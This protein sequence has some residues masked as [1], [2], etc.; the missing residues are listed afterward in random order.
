MDVI[1]LFRKPVSVRDLTF[2]SPGTYRLVCWTVGD[3]EAMPASARL[4]AF[5]LETPG[6]PI[7]AALEFIQPLD[8]ALVVVPE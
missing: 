2:T 7:W 4:H 3:Y 8:C 6:G 5:Y 1:P